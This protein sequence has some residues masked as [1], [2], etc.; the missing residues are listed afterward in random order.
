MIRSFSPGRETGDRRVRSETHM[1]ITLY[2]KSG[3]ILHY[4]D[5][6]A[7]TFAVSSLVLAAIGLVSCD[8]VVRYIQCPIERKK[9]GYTLKP[10]N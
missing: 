2:R 7:G 3:T 9:Q 5:A 4:T 1:H 6:H 8:A 10:S